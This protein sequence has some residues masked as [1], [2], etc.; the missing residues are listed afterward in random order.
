MARPQ[1]GGVS[2]LT[3]VVTAG[4]LP[5]VLLVLLAVLW[6]GGVVTLYNS[7]GFVSAPSN[8]FSQKY[9]STVGKSW[10]VSSLQLTFMQQFLEACCLLP[11]PTSS[12]KARAA[13]AFPCNIVTEEVEVEEVAA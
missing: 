1:P 3:H 4:Y 6:A 5:R 12:W 13:P 2:D 11:A 9:Q 10:K 7:R 8:H